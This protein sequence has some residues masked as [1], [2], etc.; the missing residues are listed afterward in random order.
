MAALPRSLTRRPR[1]GSRLARESTA[2]R[3]PSHPRTLDQFRRDW[4]ARVSRLPSVAAHCAIERHWTTWTSSSHANDGPCPTAGEQEQVRTIQ[5]RPALSV[6]VASHSDDV[7]EVWPRRSRACTA[8]QQSSQQRCP[9]RFPSPP[10]SRR[11][12]GRPAREASLREPSRE[13]EREAEVSTKDSRV[14]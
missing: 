3:L 11:P 9:G 8:Q 13:R 5:C 2:V 14:L 4:D 6:S 1:L 12:P 7:V 10:P